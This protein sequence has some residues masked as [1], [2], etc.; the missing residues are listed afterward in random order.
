MDLAQDY[1]EA[2]TEVCRETK[3]FT[4]TE[5]CDNIVEL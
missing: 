1:Q 4:G 2:F 3:M 5:F